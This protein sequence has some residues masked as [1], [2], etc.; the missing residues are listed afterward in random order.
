MQI[1]KGNIIMSQS[2]L[3]EISIDRFE[4]QLVENCAPTLASLKTASLFNYKM[5][6]AVQLSDSVLEL[7]RKLNPKGVFIEQLVQRESYNLIY[8][9]RPFFLEKDLRHRGACEILQRCG[10]RDLDGTDMYVNR[11]LQHLKTRLSKNACFPHEIGLFL[12]YPLEDVM[13][14]I[15]HQGRECRYCGLW[16][17][18]CNVH[19]TMELFERFRKC[20]QVY[21]QVFLEGKS[22][23]Q[24]T[25]AAYAGHNS[26]L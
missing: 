3:P 5:T 20:T 1:I 8:V 10:Y 19:D 22:I 2:S 6:D 11:C 7:N 15:S 16:K 13:G 17:V 24:M 26:V 9:Y 21:R 14:F 25:V 12:G 18:Y 4:Q 23:V